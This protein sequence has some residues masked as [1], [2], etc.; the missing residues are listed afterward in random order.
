MDEILNKIK[1]SGSEFDKNDLTQI[2]NE[3][4]KII[5]FKNISDAKNHLLKKINDKYMLKL[6]G[7]ITDFE[8]NFQQVKYMQ[9]NTYVFKIE[10]DS[11]TLVCEREYCGSIDGE[12]KTYISIG[13]DS[14][15]LF[16]SNTDDYDD[17]VEHFNDFVK[18]ND[19][20]CNVTK[21][22]K[23]D[24]C[25]KFVVCVCSLLDIVYEE[26]IFKYFE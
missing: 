20:L 11:N 16:K 6:I 2:I 24:N 15:V 12:G 5:K 17:I 1:A 25:K 19:E 8:F 23:F 3:C 7:P 4:T 9:K 22:L 26:K 10:F 14:N 18:D 21:M 13:L